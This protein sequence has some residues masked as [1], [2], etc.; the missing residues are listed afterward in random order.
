VSR[1]YFGRWLNESGFTAFFSSANGVVALATSFTPEAAMAAKEF[2]MVEFV[3]DCV[4]AMVIDRANESA[5]GQPRQYV[6]RGDAYCTERL[7]RLDQLGVTIFRCLIRTRGGDI[8]NSRPGTPTFKKGTRLS[9]RRLEEA[10]RLVQTLSDLVA[11][12]VT[13]A[14]EGTSAEG[15]DV[16]I[17]ANVIVSDPDGP[18]GIAALVTV[19]NAYDPEFDNREIQIL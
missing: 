14:V 4:A 11:D 1:E 9:L 16:L 18:R 5:E 19:I 13:E 6:L 8:C 7:D 2:A 12:S 3:N 15:Y 10:A 17:E